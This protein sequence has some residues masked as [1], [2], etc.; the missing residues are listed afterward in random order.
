MD[1][2]MNV[3]NGISSEMWIGF[4]ALVGSFVGCMITFWVAE[5]V[6]FREGTRHMQKHYEEMAS[7]KRQPEITEM[8]APTEMVEAETELKTKPVLEID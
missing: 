2:I 3:I 1:A 7:R 5:G 4:G 6:G 8:P